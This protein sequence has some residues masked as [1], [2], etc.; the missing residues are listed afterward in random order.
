MNDIVNKFSLARYK[1]RLV[2]HLRHHEFT[3]SASGSFKKN[4]ERKQKFKKGSR[5]IYQNELDKACFQPGVVNGDFEDLT[6]RTASDKN[7]FMKLL[8]L[9]KIQNMIDI[10]GSCFNVLYIFW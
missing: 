8:I 10:K 1:F 7:C 2:I 9:L 4:K 5:Y 3:Y 6:R